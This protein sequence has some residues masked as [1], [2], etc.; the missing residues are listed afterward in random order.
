MVE[1]DGGGMGKDSP[2][3]CKGERSAALSLAGLAC[4]PSAATHDLCG[5]GQ[6]PQPPWDS[7]FLSVIWGQ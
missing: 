4:K 1:A 6:G 2:P 7:V 3:L 5:L